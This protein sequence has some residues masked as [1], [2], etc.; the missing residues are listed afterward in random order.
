MENTSEP[1]TTT[2]EPS[3]L[4]KR[5]RVCNGKA[6]CYNFQG[7]SCGPCRLFFYRN[8]AKFEK[9]KCK[10]NEFCRIDSTQSKHCKS[11][12]LTKCLEAGMDLS[13][14]IK[15]NLNKKSISKSESSLHSLLMQPAENHQSLANDTAPDLQLKLENG[16]LKDIF[17]PE[18]EGPSELELTTTEEALIVQAETLIREIFPDER[19][20]P[21]TGAVKHPAEPSTMAIRYV[22][23]LI[24]L[25][26]S[27]PL[28]ERLSKPEKLIILKSL[29]FEFMA[30]R[31][32]YLYDV[33]TQSVPFCSNDSFTEVYTIDF[34]IFYDNNIGDHVKLNHQLK[35]KLNG[36]IQNDSRIRD[37][38]LM[39]HIF[40]PRDG[41]TAPELFCYQHSTYCYLLRRHLEALSRQL[42]EEGRARHVKFL[43]SLDAKLVPELAAEL[44]NLT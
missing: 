8:Y 11:C 30:V 28:F 25:A 34:N 44:F 14:T 20:L 40:T 37:L 13:L 32:A 15:K 6:L 36:E 17:S 1:T 22:P 24:Q 3:T 16:K 7:L 35:E 33:A 43:E 41:L 18:L 26:N 42:K 38:L 21:V 9:L 5:C 27:F 2:T 31:V 39:Q 4:I 23:K 10:Q 29:A 19:S 12:R